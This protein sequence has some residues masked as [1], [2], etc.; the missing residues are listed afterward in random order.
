MEDHRQGRLV[1]DRNR[2]LILEHLHRSA[3]GRWDRIRTRTSSGSASIDLVELVVVVVVDV[4]GGGAEGS[5]PEAG[6]LAMSKVW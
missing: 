6:G 5:G 1:S 2:R 3:V 4:V